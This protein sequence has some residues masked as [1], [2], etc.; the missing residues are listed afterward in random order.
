MTCPLPHALRQPSLWRGASAGA[1]RPTPLRSAQQR[2]RRT[3]RAA[4]AQCVYAGRVAR[5]RQARGRDAPVESSPGSV[6][7]TYTSSSRLELCKSSRVRLGVSLKPPPTRTGFL[8]GGSGNT[9][10]GEPPKLEDPLLVDDDG[11]GGLPALAGVFRLLPP[12]RGLASPHSAEGPSKRAAS[13]T[14][15]HP[16]TAPGL[17][18][19]SG[20]APFARLRSGE[21]KQAAMAAGLRLRAGVAAGWL[22]GRAGSRGV[23]LRAEKA[24]PEFGTPPEYLGV[25]SRA[26]KACLPPYH[27]TTP[28]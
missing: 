13:T 18:P 27:S 28:G 21:E 6:R 2:R 8:I 10:V 3:E 17:A 24:L 4:S 19:P 22:P 1:G 23:A 15:V 5:E 14:G 26:P 16:L 12:E 25:P 20:L 7:L 9:L 11:S